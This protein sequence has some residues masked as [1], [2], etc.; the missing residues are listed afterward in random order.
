MHKSFSY[1]YHYNVL[2]NIFENISDLAKIFVM[3]V[4]QDL[5]HASG[6]CLKIN[7]SK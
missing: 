1:K 3:D 5:K 6:N 4:K 2:E 7:K